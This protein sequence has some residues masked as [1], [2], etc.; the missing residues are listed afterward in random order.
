MEDADIMETLKQVLQAWPSKIGETEGQIR[1]RLKGKISTSLRRESLGVIPIG[2]WKVGCPPLI[3]SGVAKCLVVDTKSS[4]LP[5][6]VELRLQHGIWEIVAF[7][8]QCPA[9]FGFGV[10]NEC[11]CAL[12][13]GVGWGCY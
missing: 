5:I 7:D 3:R 13:F 10:N 8:E 12:C 2:K 1:E 9:C 6:L 11:I 4:I